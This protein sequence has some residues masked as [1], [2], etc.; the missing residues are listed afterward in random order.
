MIT[1]NNI[2]KQKNLENIAVNTPIAKS[3]YI[4]RELNAEIYLKREFTINRKF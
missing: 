1:L 2:K 4:L 3:T